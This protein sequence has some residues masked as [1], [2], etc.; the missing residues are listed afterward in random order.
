M[1]APSKMTSPAGALVRVEV[2]HPVEHAQQRR[3]SAAGRADEGGHQPV[4]KRQ[5]D[6]LERPVVAVEEIEIADRHA[7]A[8]IGRV[9]GCVRD[10]GC[11]ER[12][13][14]HVSLL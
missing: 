6:G 10:L 14:G 1:F 7:L 8:Q 12:G 2:V 4:V 9:G 3:F 11:I 5:A 13:H